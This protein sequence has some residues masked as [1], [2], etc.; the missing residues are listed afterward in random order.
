L[1]HTKIKIPA[2]VKAAPIAIP[3][4]KALF[5]VTRTKDDW[6]FYIIKP[7]MPQVNLYGHGQAL[8]GMNEYLT[9]NTQAK[10]P[11]QIKRMKS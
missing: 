11:P 4:R 5:S 10:F 6:K 2:A 1:F 3:G 9:Y 8:I 7:E